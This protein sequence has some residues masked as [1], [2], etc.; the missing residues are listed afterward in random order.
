MFLAINISDSLGNQ[1]SKVGSL[2][3]DQL[4]AAGANDP[5]I[6]SVGLAFTGVLVDVVG[7]KGFAGRDAFSQDAAEFAESSAE[8][9]DQIL[10]A[11]LAVLSFLAWLLWKPN[12][13]AVDA[14]AFRPVGAEGS[15]LE[16]RFK[17]LAAFWAGRDP[18]VVFSQCSGVVKFHGV[19]FLAS[20]LVATR[21][22]GGTGR[23]VG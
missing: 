4:V 1:V 18:A 11:G 15:D 2:V 14:G 8:A 23:L 16:G 13:P 9:S 17:P 21:A 12:R 6:N 10:V 20:S 19:Q 7:L 3:V 22:A 5:E